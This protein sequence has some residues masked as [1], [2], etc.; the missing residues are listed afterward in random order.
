MGMYGGVSILLEPPTDFLTIPSKALHEI[1]AGG[2]FI[3]V[4]E[5][6]RARKRHLRIG[7]DNGILVEVISGLTTEDEVIV[8]Y[9][10]SLQDGE[11]VDAAPAEGIGKAGQ[12]S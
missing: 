10:G 2:G 12:D 11:P 4:A 7:R 8:G 5:G 1:E 6:G 9:T 3:Y